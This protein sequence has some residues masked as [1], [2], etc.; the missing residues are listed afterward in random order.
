MAES[1]KKGLTRRSMLGTTA[2]AAVAGA[3]GATAGLGLAQLR[4]VT[5][6]EAQSPPRAASP[7]AS[8]EVAPG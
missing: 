4:G 1:E 3:A 2:A 6:A 8:F 7:H 5:E